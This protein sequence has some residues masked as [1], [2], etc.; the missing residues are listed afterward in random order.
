MNLK[1]SG[2]WFVV[3][4][5]VTLSTASLV[6]MPTAATTVKSARIGVAQEQLTFTPYKASGIYSAGEKVGWTASLAPGAVGGEYAYTIKKNNQDTI[7]TGTLDLSTGP[8]GIEVTLDEPAMV[9]VEV[10][11]RGTPTGGSTKN[12]ALGA[13]VSPDKLQPSVSRPADFDSFWD[14]KIKMLK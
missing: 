2:R 13:A 5:A 10:S 7:K 12:I 8:A 9:Y 4:V 3:A 6:P 1:R 11:P 14:A